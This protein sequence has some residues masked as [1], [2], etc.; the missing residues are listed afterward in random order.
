MT[1]A[2]PAIDVQGLSPVAL[3]RRLGI[4]PRKRFSQSFLI[5]PAMPDLIARTAELSFDDAVLE[6]GPGV[7]VL[8][9]ALASRVR[10]VIS[11]EIDH[12]LAQRLPSLLPSNVRVINADATLFAPADVFDRP[13]ALVANLPYHVTSPVLLRYID[14]VPKPFRLVVMVQREVAERICS[15]PGELSFL[16]V[17]IQSLYSARLVR[18]VPPGCFHPRPNVESAVIRLDRLDT[19]MVEPSERAAF[20]RTVDA[21]FRQPR[22]QLANSLAQGLGV[23]RSLAARYLESA[24]IALTIRAQHVGIDGWARL[25]R[26]VAGPP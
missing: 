17:A 25:A 5:D 1:S 6:I 8:T 21:G 7:G 3:L 2:P 20:L 19:P 22:K 15:P 16:A 12:D 18:V 24:Q 23:D 9:R 13:Y 4:R 10:Q 26:V 14:L 11:V